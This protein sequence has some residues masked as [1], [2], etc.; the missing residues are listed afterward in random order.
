MPNEA[1]HDG[2]TPVHVV[3]AEEVPVVPLALVAVIVQLSPAEPTP[4]GAEPEHGAG[5]LTLVDPVQVYSHGDRGFPGTSHFLMRYFASH[6]WVSVARWTYPPR[7]QGHGD[8]QS[9]E[10]HAWDAG[11][12]ECPPRPS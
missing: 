8:H 6:G 3:L 7:P 9:P 2:A 10:H 12:T 5:P 11:G 4:T 1:V